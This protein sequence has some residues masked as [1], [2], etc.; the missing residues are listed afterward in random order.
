MGTHLPAPNHL[1]R[2]SFPLPTPRHTSFFC[3]QTPHLQNFIHL[4]AMTLASR[5]TNG[6]D[7]VSIAP[8]AATTSAAPHCSQGDH[9]PPHPFDSLLHSF[10]DLR[11]NKASSSAT[12]SALFLSGKP[13]IPATFPAVSPPPIITNARSSPITPCCLPLLPITEC[14]RWRPAWGPPSPSRKTSQW[15]QWRSRPPSPWRA[16]AYRAS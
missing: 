3:S 8:T 14:V 12:A 10:S 5:F 11:A 4:H 9:G 2:H 15:S 1:L 7:F 13:Q 16:E 6:S